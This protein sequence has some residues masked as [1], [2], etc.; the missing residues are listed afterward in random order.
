MPPLL[1][2]FSALPPSFPSPISAP[3]TH[4]IHSLI[5]I[6]IVPSLRSIW[7][8]PSSSSSVP[9]SQSPSPK[10]ASTS[11]TPHRSASSSRGDSPS[12][13]HPHPAAPKP[14][15]LDRALSVLAAG[16]RSLSR[17]SSPLPPSVSP[18]E[19]S[20]DLLEV[21]L[22]HYFPGTEEADAQSVRDRCKQES[23]GV[24]TLDDLLS[25]LIVLVT[26]FCVADENSRS[27]VRHWLV[28]ED[29]DRSAPLE[30]RA[31]TLGRCLRLLSSVYHPRI[32]DSVGEMLF[33][34]SGSNGT[35]L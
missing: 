27:R 23:D 32:K 21:A 19:R 3:L 25:P 15:T 12:R 31:D 8:A 1:R 9:H 33:A 34:M 18:L 7:L 20:I 10:T 17:S 35:F 6:P 24:N 22:T 28:P 2:A 16:R 29:M 4:V 30:G 11:T 14:S 13:A 26:R 5:T